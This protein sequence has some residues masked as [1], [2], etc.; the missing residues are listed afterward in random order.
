MSYL[1]LLADTE[2]ILLEPSALA[3]MTGPIHLTTQ[4]VPRKKLLI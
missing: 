1:A 2:N 4:G 3:G